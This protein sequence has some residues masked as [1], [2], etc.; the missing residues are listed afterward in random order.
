M[1]QFFIKK[2]RIEN[3]LAMK[4]I[5]QCASYVL[6]FDELNISFLSIKEESTPYNC[7]DLNTA[8]FITSWNI[9]LTLLFYNSLSQ[10]NST[11]K[12]VQSSSLCIFTLLCYVIL[13]LT[14]P[15]KG[16]SLWI[17]KNATRSLLLSLLFI[18]VTYKTKKFIELNNIHR[19]SI[20]DALLIIIHSFSLQSLAINAEIQEHVT[21]FP[22]FFVALFDLCA[23][24]FKIKKFKQLSFGDEIDLEEET[25]CTICQ[26]STTHATKL[27]CGH[28]FHK[29][30]LNEWTMKSTDCPLCRKIIEK[31]DNSFVGNIIQNI[32]ANNNEN[33]ENVNDEN[34]N[35]ENEQINGWE[36]VENDN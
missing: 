28:V 1:I 21:I 12:I 14:L 17:L 15:N 26:E 11:R 9:C 32:N 13:G 3:S 22:Y 24:K 16:I 20:Y 25:V 7:F 18:L 4:W 2:F 8:I 19:L 10:Q 34:I 27:K 30:C 5:V 35:D 23:I 29:Q 33:N 36:I 31:S 6:V